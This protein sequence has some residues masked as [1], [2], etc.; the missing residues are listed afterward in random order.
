MCGIYDIEQPDKTQLYDLESDPDERVN[1]HDEQTELLRYFDQL[2]LQHVAQGLLKHLQ[3]QIPALS[4]QHEMEEDAELL[5]R[6]AALG[7]W[8]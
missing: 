1:L 8:A 3:T 5:D 2:R 6:L 4:Q 7:Y